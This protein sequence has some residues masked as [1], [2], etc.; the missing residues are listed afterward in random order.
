MTT[1][2]LTSRFQNELLELR[3]QR[4]SKAR[5]QTYEIQQEEEPDEEPEAYEEFVY[6]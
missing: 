3:R 6:V 1:T 4:E 5:K 2:L